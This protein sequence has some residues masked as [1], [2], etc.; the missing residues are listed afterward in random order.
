MA[1]EIAEELHR[2]FNDTGWVPQPSQRWYFAAEGVLPDRFQV[3]VTTQ[4]VRLLE[5]GKL[6]CQEI[7][8]PMAGGEETFWQELGKFL[9][10]RST[11]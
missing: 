2:R 4:A 5:A 11:E 10:P 8:L 9:Q 7:P 1:T 6:L 3:E